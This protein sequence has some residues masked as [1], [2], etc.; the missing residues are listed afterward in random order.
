VKEKENERQ[1]LNEI[2]WSI[3]K[4]EVGTQRDSENGKR[5]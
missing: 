3:K 1:S 5:D 2:V 4:K